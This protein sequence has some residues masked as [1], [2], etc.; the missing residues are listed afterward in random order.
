M[1][2]HYLTVTNQEDWSEAITIL[3]QLPGV[4]II[5]KEPKYCFVEIL[6]IDEPI[7]T[8]DGIVNVLTSQD[9]SVDW[10]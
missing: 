8:V 2:R 7:E 4:E 3:E 1:E 10:D 6:L 5:N 9:I